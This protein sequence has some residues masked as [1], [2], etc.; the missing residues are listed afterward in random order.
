MEKISKI[1]F[2]FV[3]ILLVSS[4]RKKDIID[5]PLVTKVVKETTENV[6]EKSSKTTVKSFIKEFGI[7]EKYLKLLDDK[8]LNILR[9]DLL[10]PKYKVFR[11]KI[12]KN[13]ELIGAYRLVSDNPAIRLEIRYLESITKQLKANP[14]K[15]PIIELLN[16]HNKK[17]A[18]EVLNGVP[19]VKRTLKQN[20]YDVVGVFPD[21]S[22]YRLFSHTLNKEQYLLKDAQQ[23]D[24]GKAALANEYK[25]NPKKVK[26]MLRELNKGKEY[27]FNGKILKGEDMLEKQI[28]D[29]TNPKN[30]KVFGFIWH[31]NE[32][33]GVME[34]VSQKAHDGVRHIGGKSTWGGGVHYR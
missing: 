20:G 4:C 33:D 14:N 12:L 6:I 5:N 27:T 31:H 25:K 34:L 19:F 2:L 8:Q 13:P 32:K 28:L 24:I 26:A 30:N 18:G 1:S 11:E 22:N 15:K 29:I 16:N 23:F 3:L 10:T 7:D 21:F 9:N 17:Y